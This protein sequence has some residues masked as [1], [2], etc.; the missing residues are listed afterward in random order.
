MIK[1]T[2]ESADIANRELMMPLDASEGDWKSL[3]FESRF[4]MQKLNF[5]SEKPHWNKSKF[6]SFNHLFETLRYSYIDMFK[7]TL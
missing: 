3:P 6:L 1:E 4:Y 7:S 5:P 2:I